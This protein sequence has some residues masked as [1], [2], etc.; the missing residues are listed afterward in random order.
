MWLKY[1]RS[2]CKEA[3]LRAE[4]RFIITRTVAFTSHPHLQLNHFIHLLHI[5]IPR[6]GWE[7]FVK[8]KWNNPGKNKMFLFIDTMLPNSI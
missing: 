1:I 6:S 2:G 7:I 8:T 5:K 4:L 3:H